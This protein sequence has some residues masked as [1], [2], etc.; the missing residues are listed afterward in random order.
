MIRMIQ[1]SNADHAKA[2]FKQALSKADYYINDQELNGHIRGKLAERL[3]I[4]GIATKETFFALCDNIDP[5][6]GQQLTPRTKAERRIGYDINFHCPKSL[7]ILHALS[8]DDHLMKAFETSVHATM[9]DIEADCKARVRKDGQFADRQTGELAWADFVHQTA[10]PVDGH[11]PDPHLH[12]H[13]F[14]F[15]A[16]WDG[17]EQRI[18]AGEFGDIKRDMPYY[19][20]RF[21]KYL[22]D[23]LIDLG[24]G[25]RRTDKSFEIEN[26]PERVI[27][28][29][30]KRTDEIGRIAKE[31]GI[32]DI[33]ELGELGARTRAKKQQGVGMSE[34]KADWRRQIRELGSEQDGKG[35]RAVRNAPEKL[36]EV[37]HAKDCVDHALQ[38][39]FE[40]ASVIHDRRLLESAYRHS[41]GQRTISLDQIT[42]HLNADQRLIGITDRGQKLMT[43]RE[44]LSEEHY[45]VKLA[46]SGQGK[47][48]PL[49]T[50][51]PKVKLDGQQ[52]EAV[53]HLLTTTDRVSIIRGAAG[54]GKTTLMQEAIKHMEE[55]GKTVM[56][57][58]PT[59]E[60]SRG[61]LRNEGF[62]EAETVSQLLVDKKLQEK[63]KDQVLWVDEAGL[64]G[65]KDMT[66]LLDL[67]TKQNARLVLG[68]DTRQH[69][70]VVRG[71]ALRILNTVGEIKT[72]E[73]S[74]IYRQRNENY[75]KAVEDLSA[76]NVKSAFEKLDASGAIK[77]IDP[78]SPNNQLIDDYM[79]AIKNKKTALV[80]SP[81][82]QQAEDVT[83]T[84]RQKLQSSGELGKREITINRLV[85]R[86]LTEAQRADWRNINEG[87]IIQFNQNVAGIQRG[88]RWQVA[89]S[90]DHHVLIKDAQ[91]ETQT[92][93]TD[94]SAYYDVYRTKSLNLAKGDKVRITRIGFD[95]RD[96]RLNNGQHLKVTSVKKDG[97]IE[98]LGA[99]NKTNY[100]I[101]K[102]FGHIA[103]AY[104]I[105]SH[106]SQGKTVDEVFISQPAATFPATSSKQF[107]VSAS[108]GR[109]KVHIY[110][111]DK[112]ELLT[113]AQRLGDRQSALELMQKR[114]NI[115]AIAEQVVRE[116]PVL[117]KDKTPTRT[118]TSKQRTI[119]IDYEPRV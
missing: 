46:R 90:N 96:K 62:A 23:N 6:T 83:D 8:D 59:S 5:A 4:D 76:G 65:T 97:R 22:S 104:C 45:M 63:L 71:D 55:A 88:S 20:A 24:Y 39:G 33:D 78:L 89:Y 47:L 116:R 1:A 85:N 107:Y 69:S 18:K 9:R 31:K 12:A 38:H 11:L 19:Q 35:E 82:H 51:S 25:I 40:R 21:H 10:R 95:E 43:I 113:H 103:H 61:V 110:T 28:L 93:P 57:V 81:T 16:T 106:A 54:S 75:R 118:I 77:E 2:Y 80:I 3:G 53:K 42:G 94:K 100:K 68:G 26:V 29:F 119:D 48:R 27:D 102:D 58:A 87:N 44:V 105:T 98:L 73:V 64:L 79:L 114:K 91:G 15:N 72:A 30:S 49:Y 50:N 70:S 92:L 74:K 56:V 7:S 60:A 84:I 17:V 41:I 37:M 34:L 67:T 99:D 32:T 109:D 52:G 86:N 112:E 13:C 36:L 66:A 111:D 14:V 101:D 117:Q 108:R 115:Q